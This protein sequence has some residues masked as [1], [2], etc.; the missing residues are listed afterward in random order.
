M[1]CSTMQYSVVQRSRVC[2]VQCNV[3]FRPAGSLA[4]A[5]A[6]AANWTAG[7]LQHCCHCSLPYSTTAVTVLCT[8][9]LLLSLFSTLLYYCCRSVLMLLYFILLYY[10]CCIVL[11]YASS[12]V[13][14]QI[15]Y[16][17]TLLLMHCFC[18]G[19]V[20]VMLCYCTVTVVRVG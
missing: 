5:V 14:T 10:C 6:G 11:C 12:A 4:L 20:I 8:S 7:L 2:A 13:P 19:S 3:G 1:P 16:S 17:K 15:Y 9:V 18:I